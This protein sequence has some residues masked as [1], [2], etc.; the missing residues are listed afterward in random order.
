[1]NKKTAIEQ[2]E[3]LENNL[4]NTVS[5][6]Y[7]DNKKHKAISG[8]LK[9]ING[10]DSITIDEKEISFFHLHQSIIYIKLG[11]QIIFANTSVDNNY[12]VD[13]LSE[14]EKYETKF[15]GADIIK[16]K[17][18]YLKTLYFNKIK[19]EDNKEK[20]KYILMGLEEIEKEKHIDWLDWSFNES[21][22]FVKTVAV[23]MRRLTNGK[24]VE[25]VER[26]YKT[27]LGLE[28][29]DEFEN[30][31]LEFYYIRKTELRKHIEKTRVRK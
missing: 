9:Q 17:E 27:T 7:L 10:F 30:I 21:L 28:N 24:S 11:K 29:L 19:K 3:N 22:E 4:G 16:N 6:I 1:M 18:Q 26:F 8:V 12:N 15:L 2:F 20:Y 14:I 5:C 25:E 23:S 13:T 31:I